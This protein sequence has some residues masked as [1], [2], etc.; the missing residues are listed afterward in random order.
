MGIFGSSSEPSPNG[1]TGS[2]SGRSESSTSSQRHHHLKSPASDKL[3]NNAASS[4][5]AAKMGGLPRLSSGEICDVPTPSPIQNRQF[6]PVRFNFNSSSQ[7][8]QAAAAAAAASDSV[9]H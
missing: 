9:F 4:T 1:I 6:Q 2:G 5:A 8:P 3:N 7:H